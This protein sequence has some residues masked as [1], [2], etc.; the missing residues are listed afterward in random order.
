M[1]AHFRLRVLN[2]G[3][4]RAAS[5]FP[6]LSVDHPSALVGLQQ[7][8]DWLD[9]C[10]MQSPFLLGKEM[11]PKRVDTTGPLTSAGH[12]AAAPQVL[13]CKYCKCSGTLA[14]MKRRNQYRGELHAPGAHPQTTEFLG[15]PCVRGAD[16]IG[17]TANAQPPDM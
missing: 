4:C 17:S 6:A 2:M 9:A 3:F 11:A 10:T 1:C 7:I 8:H 12:H 15:A 16:R 5:H 14:T 13:F